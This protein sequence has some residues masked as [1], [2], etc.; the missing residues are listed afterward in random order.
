MEV[1]STQNYTVIKSCKPTI[2]NDY[3]NNDNDNYIITI[4]PILLG[5]GDS[6]RAG[7]IPSIKPYLSDENISRLKAANTNKASFAY[8]NNDNNDNNN[9]NNNNNNNDNN[10]N[11]D[12][13]D[14]KMTYRIH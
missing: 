2:Y 9:N 11:K 14:N 3:Y 10:N 4:V 13:K 6:V 5:A 7:T 1:V 8:D 12:N